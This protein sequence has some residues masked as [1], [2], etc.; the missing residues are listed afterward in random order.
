MFSA[1]EGICGFLTFKGPSPGEPSP[2]RMQVA[3]HFLVQDSAFLDLGFS[4]DPMT[5]ISIEAAAAVATK[6][7]VIARL[8]LPTAF[9]TTFFLL[10]LLSNLHL[11]LHT[12]WFFICSDCDSCA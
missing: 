11:T 2:P 9:A 12:P 5:D 7:I 3:T 10:V 6:P 8:L 1:E 4:F